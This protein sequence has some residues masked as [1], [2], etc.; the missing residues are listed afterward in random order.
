MHGK[1]RRLEVQKIRNG[2]KTGEEINKKT[3]R[4]IFPFF[5]LISNC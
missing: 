5:T 1:N 3:G 2:K 4:K